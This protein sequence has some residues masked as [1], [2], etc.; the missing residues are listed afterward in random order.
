[1]TTIE[2]TERIL[3]NVSFTLKLTKKYFF[4]NI[5]RQRQMSKKINRIHLMC[6]E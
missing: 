6:K 4:S 2:F 3:M 1:M 5:D